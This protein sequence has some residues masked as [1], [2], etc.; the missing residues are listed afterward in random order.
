MLLIFVLLCK[1]D[2][3]LL[4]TTG[5]NRIMCIL[6]LI[7]KK[8]MGHFHHFVSS[9]SSM[10]SPISIFSCKIT[11]VDLCVCVLSFI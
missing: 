5:N 4:Q 2:N 9:R 6:D 3:C 11:S 1:I 8:Q 10:C 7:K